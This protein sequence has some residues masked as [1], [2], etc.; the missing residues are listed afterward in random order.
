MNN[1]EAPLVAQSQ[2]SPSSKQ[3]PVSLTTK[4]VKQNYGTSDQAA[5]SPET[6]DEEIA[7]A[8]ERFSSQPH[9]A[10]GTNEELP[11][12]SNQVE[13]G[14]LGSSRSGMEVINISQ[15]IETSQELRKMFEYA[16]SIISKSLKQGNVKVY[17]IANRE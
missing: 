13:T 12:D 15:G 4:A 1:S 8:F 14:S 16:E 2:A 10:P 5:L 9:K 3:R 11:S 17:V 7:R 6:P